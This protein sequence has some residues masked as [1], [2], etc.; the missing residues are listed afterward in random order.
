MHSR[1]PSAAALRGALSLV[2]S[3]L[4]APFLHAATIPA[5]GPLARVEG[6]C[7]PSASGSVTLG[8]PGVTVH[9]SVRGPSLN[10]TAKATASEV[11]FDVIVDGRLEGRVRLKQ[12]LSDTRLFG[13]ATNELHQVEIVHVTESSNGYCEIESFTSEAFE[14]PPAPP[15]HRLLF[16]GD[17]FTCGAATECRPGRPTPATK[18]LR[19]NARLSY[20][21]IL[22]RR[23]SSDVSLV[24]YAGRGLIRDW[25]GLQSPQPAPEFYEYALADDH[26]TAWRHASF[27]PDAIGVCLG[28][29]FDS[30]IPDEA[31][32]V[33]SYTEFLRKLQRDAPKAAILLIVS[34]VIWDAEDGPP[35]HTVLKAYLNEVV[36]RLNS[37][38]VSVVDVGNYHGV[39]GDGHPDGSAHE[40]VAHILEPRLRAAL[41]LAAQQP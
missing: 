22:S 1:N 9:L 34:P 23:L 14:A 31:E 36:R 18:S 33:R 12:G 37:P 3:L 11:D 30:G 40:T 24:S 32:Y 28:N 20:G 5:S 4:L 2:V 7:V 39:P 15:A 29:D 21:W 10:M 41:G 6:R 8:Y 26:S 25:E 19:Q 17:S 16:I 38:S 27:V 13:N 35:R